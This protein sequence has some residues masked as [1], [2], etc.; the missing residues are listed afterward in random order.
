[1]FL[2]SF[3]QYGIIL[4]LDFFLGIFYSTFQH[5]FKGL[6]TQMFIFDAWVPRVGK[7]PSSWSLS[8]F[9]LGLSITL[10]SFQNKF[11]NI[12]VAPVLSCSLFSHSL[13]LKY[14]NYST[15]CI[16]ISIDWTFGPWIKKAHSSPI[17]TENIRLMPTGQ[18]YFS[19]FGFT[20]TP[21]MLGCWGM[22]NLSSTEK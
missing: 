13:I 4:K 10:F 19:T 16:W 1:M 21:Y 15:F 17:S 2:S 9:R 12:F 5:V 18:F 3:I 11:G 7:Y 8:P 20:S 6:W 14:V 22:R